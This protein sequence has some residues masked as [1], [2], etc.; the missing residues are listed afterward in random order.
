MKDCSL[1]YRNRVFYWVK[2]AEPNGFIVEQ[3]DRYAKR[4]LST[5]WF[6]FRYEAEQYRDK[7]N[8]QIL[9]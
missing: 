3:Y 6:L 4:V 9:N 8:Q 5:K 1:G 2:P 7:Q